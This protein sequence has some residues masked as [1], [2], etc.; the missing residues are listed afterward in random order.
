MKNVIKKIPEIVVTNIGKMITPAVGIILD[1]YVFDIEFP[2]NRMSWTFDR[3]QNLV[4]D[5]DLENRRF[6]I[7]KSKNGWIGNETI[8]LR[9]TNHSGKSVSSSLNGQVIEAGAH[10]IIPAIP[11]IAL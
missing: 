4:L 7:V 2:A 9:V 6:H 10:P 3:S 5:I 11:A 8:T 1:D